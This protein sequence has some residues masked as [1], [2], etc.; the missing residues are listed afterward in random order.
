MQQEKHWADKIADK[1]IKDNPG[2]KKFICA[3]GISPSGRIHI[4]NFRDMITSNLI[5]RALKD[6]GH[7]AEL[8]FSWDDYDRFRKVPKGVP[9]KF[10]KYLGMPLSKVPDPNGCHE[11]YAKHFEEEFEKVMPELGIEQRF[12]YQS[13]EYEK[14]KY[15]GKIK[16]ALKKRKDIAKI[17]AKFKTQG[18]TDEEIENYY[19]LQVYCEKC[20]KDIA[21][22]VDYDGE[23]IITY[24]CKCGHKNSVDISKKNIGKLSWKIDWAMRWGV[25]GVSFE[26][27]GED[28]A[29]P[30]GSYDVSSKIA[31]EI[32]NI[33]PPIFQGYG[34]VGVEGISKIS[35][36][37]GGGIAPKDLIEIYEAEL[38]RWLFT[39]AN[40][41][42]AITLFF[43]SQIIRQYD[44]FDREIKDFYANNASED[45]KREIIFSSINPKEPPARIRTPFRQ[46][47]SFG[48][49]AQGNFKELKNMFKKVGKEFDD[50]ALK[51]RLEKSQNWVLRFAPELK[52]N[53][54]DKPNK[55]YF[56]KLINE[57]KEQINKLNDGL[58]ENWDLEKLTLLVYA[59][60]N[61]LGIDEKEKKKRQRDFFK[62]VYQMLIDKDTGPRLA[63]FLIALGKKRVKEIL[64]V[65]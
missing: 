28:H 47:T 25:E 23:N 43:D 39:R 59:I 36:S 11:S 33:K 42:K 9:A 41:K 6:K 16:T 7:D 31:E 61:K 19:P 1:L 18:M 34:F 62:D 50:K 32:Y 24:E 3:A 65:K 5:C 45:K 54:R 60:P 37:S 46:V 22:I 30:Q 38:L 52:I 8:I 21:K 44:E 17:L 15:Y 35:G 10:S 53:V 58:D 26:P 64:N 14:N 55:D 12:I 20:E 56:D 40:P 48:Q 29:T 63:T 57:K 27:G 51:V 4:G 13:K 49:I 2:K